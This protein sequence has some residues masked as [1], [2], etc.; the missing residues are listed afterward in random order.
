VEIIVDDVEIFKRGFSNF[1]AFGIVLLVKTAS[2]LEAGIRFG[3]GARKTAFA[4]R[5]NTA[6]YRARIAA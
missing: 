5:G 4:A 6:S 1:D 3:G 2:N